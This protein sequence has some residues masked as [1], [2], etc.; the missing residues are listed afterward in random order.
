LLPGNEAPA[1]EILVWPNAGMPAPY[2][3]A[4]C[5]YMECVTRRLWAY[6]D[7]DGRAGSA[8]DIGATR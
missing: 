2:I 8:G 6:G 1:D 3:A 5:S 7:F 4:L